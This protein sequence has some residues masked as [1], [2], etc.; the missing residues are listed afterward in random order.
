M[1]K[2]NHRRAKRYAPQQR[3]SKQRRPL[4][5]YM[6]HERPVS[7]AGSELCTDCEQKILGY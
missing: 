7:H 6:C 3:D 2:H 5:C 1:T 4:D